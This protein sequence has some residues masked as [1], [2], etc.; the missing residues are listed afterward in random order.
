MTFLDSFL[1]I[2]DMHLVR[3]SSLTGFASLVTAHDGDPVALLAIAGVD[4]ADAG[5]DDRFIPLR[6]AITA[7]ETA[8]T[9]L[10]VPDFGRQLGKRQSIDI[11]GPVSVAARTAATA[12]EALDVLV[13]HMDSHSPGISAR[14]TAHTDPELRRFEYEFLLRPAPPQAQALELALALTLQVLRLFLGAGYRPKAVHLPHPPLTADTEY[15]KFFGCP[16]H[17]NEPVAGFTL[18]ASDLQRPLNHDPLAHRVALAYLSDTQ[19]RR[20]PDLADTVGSIIR[21]LLP[22]GELSAE[23]VARQFGIGSKTL[24]RRLVTEGTSYAELVDGTRRELAHRL[25]TGTDLP[26]AQVSRQLGYAEHS[27]F[28]RACR[29]WFGVAPTE[30]RAGG[31]PR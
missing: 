10:G 14:I 29:R 28:T 9:L 22:T 8:A 23:Q 31:R 15:R 19:R 2:L 11:L 5:H 4:P 27:V 7:V 1:T 12:G 21:Q 26:V 24:Q 6:S 17:F 30:Y 20:A 25:L 16:S 3:G 13:T 18:H